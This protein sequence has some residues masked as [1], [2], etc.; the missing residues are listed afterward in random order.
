[1][2]TKLLQTH[3]TGDG[4]LSFADFVGYIFPFWSKQF[5]EETI[6]R[7]IPHGSSPTMAAGGGSTGKFT[8]ASSLESPSKARRVVVVAA[9]GPSSPAGGAA[10][11]IKAQET[12]EEFVTTFSMAA[13]EDSEHIAEM[14]E[15]FRE[16]SKNGNLTLQDLAR[17]L[18]DSPGNLEAAFLEC[19]VDADG[20]L[21]LEEFLSFMS[22]T[23]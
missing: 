18:G 8:A 6:Q 12:V 3:L 10:G 15:F 14:K 5:C 20:V 9:S 2:V 17:G 19:D 13:T 1:V 7:L 16:Y 11:A 23:S 4:E 22:A 21:S